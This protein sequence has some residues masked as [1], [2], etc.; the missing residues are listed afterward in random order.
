M[1]EPR[2]MASMPLGTAPG[3]TMLASISPHIF[4]GAKMM[5]ST[6][7]VVRVK[8]TRNV[9]MSSIVRAIFLPNA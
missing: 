1:I 2:V 7:I 9:S 5:A 4:G 3:V 6:V 8:I